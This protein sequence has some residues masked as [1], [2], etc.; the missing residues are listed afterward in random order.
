MIPSTKL[1]HCSY[2]KCL[3]GYFSTVFDILFNK[4]F[5]LSKGYKHFDSDLNSFKANFEQYKV[6]SINNH[7]LEL[8]KIGDFKMSRFVRDPRDMIVS[9]YFYHKRGAEAWCN[10]INPTGSDDKIRN[11]KILAQMGGEHSFSSYLNSLSLEEGL[12]TEIEF[13]RLHFEEMARF[14]IEDDRVIIFKYEDIL[15][16]ESTVFNEI[17]DF[18]GLTRTQKAVGGYLAHRYSAENQK[19]K[20]AH[21]RDPQ[22]SQ[23]K[24]VFT[25]KVEK[26]FNELFSDV[27]TVYGYD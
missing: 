14:P 1:I 19:G 9:G 26:R 15:G 27:L 13:R 16:N 4:V 7:T 5:F 8:D 24:N 10:I 18:Y 11:Q 3:T 23:W 12:L 25:P 20:K 17:F 6:S 21:I 22:S 2:H